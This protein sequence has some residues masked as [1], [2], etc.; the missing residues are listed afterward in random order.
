MPNQFHIRRHVAGF[1][2]KDR[3]VYKY[4]CPEYISDR[5]SYDNYN[6]CVA[7]GDPLE[8]SCDVASCEHHSVTH[9]SVLITDSSGEVIGDLGTEFG[10]DRELAEAKAEALNRLSDG[11]TRY[12][13]GETKGR[14]PQ[15]WIKPNEMQ[16]ELRLKSRVNKSLQEFR[17]QIDRSFLEGDPPAGLITGLKVPDEV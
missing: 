10:V 17:E 2:L 7:C 14:K 13:V 6:N 3:P 1:I 8:I 4:A 11:E 9:Y 5:T 12:R 16:A 15:G